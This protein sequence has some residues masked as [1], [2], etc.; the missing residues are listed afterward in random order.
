MKKN[1]LYCL[2]LI[3][4]ASCGG[5]KS[6]N[7]VIEGEIRG[8]SN[9]TIYMYGADK[10]YDR[11]DTI[12]IREG[13]FSA[14]LQI[15]TLVE[16]ML[17]FPDGTEYPLFLNKGDGLH[18]NG[19]AGNLSFIDVKGTALNEELSNFNKEI[20]NIT[21]QSIRAEK[22][23]KYIKSHPTS[24]VSIYLLDHY[25]VQI[26]NPDIKK[27]KSLIEP[28]TGGLKDRPY[29]EKLLNEI[30]DDDKL[31][32]GTTL[33]YFYLHNTK[34]KSISLSNF[35]GQYMLIHFW[36][37]WDKNSR[38]TNKTY[39]DLYKKELKNK[40]FTLLGISLDTD[41]LEWREA[42]NKDS[43]KWEQASDLSGWNGTVVKQFAIQS[44]PTN[45]LVNPSGMIIGKNL[46]TTEIREKIKEP[47]K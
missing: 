41:K 23:E 32:I 34:D 33:P 40:N 9:D 14:N 2:M 11:T 36:A 13:K 28:M 24:L 8:L 21:S 12:L 35:S 31:S 6:G 17:L 26:P 44:L 4:L 39:R 19:S 46:N 3:F 22:V 7:T 1:Y 38:E 15:D 16:T 37:S 47:K 27:I 29:I 10:M 43:L 5:K 42:I 45:I 30:Q 18:I 20:K 25:F